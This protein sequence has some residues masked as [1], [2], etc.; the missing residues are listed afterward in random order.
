[1]YVEVGPIVL[2]SVETLCVEDLV[3]DKYGVEVDGL[4]VDSSVV[5]SKVSASV[6]GTM[7]DKI[8]MT[9][10]CSAYSYVY[11]TQYFLSSTGLNYSKIHF[12]LSFTYMKINFGLSSIYFQFYCM[13]QNIQL[14]TMKRRALH[15][16][17]L[18]VYQKSTSTHTLQS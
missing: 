13:R 6:A 3:V 11:V 7:N 4:G 16:Y 5:S 14:E 12:I 17:D 2:R 18:K 9:V 8:T 15:C 10:Q 1:M